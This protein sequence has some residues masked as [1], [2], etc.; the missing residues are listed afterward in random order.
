MTL[1]LNSIVTIQSGGAEG[2]VARLIS[3]DVAK[4]VDSSATQEPVRRGPASPAEECS[5]TGRAANL[6]RTWTP[7]WPS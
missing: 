3:I 2:R 4:L 7:S 5:P 6:G 1:T